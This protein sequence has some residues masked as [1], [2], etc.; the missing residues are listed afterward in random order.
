MEPTGMQ[1]SARNALEVVQKLSSDKQQS[2]LIHD[3][4]N[5][6]GIPFL[7]YTA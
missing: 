7:S 4:G 2:T 1:S 6:S 3:F 5:P